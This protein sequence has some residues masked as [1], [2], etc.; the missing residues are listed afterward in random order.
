MTA[1]QFAK[2]GQMKF[3]C[4]YLP[5]DS[6]R[7]ASMPGMRISMLSCCA[8]AL[9]CVLIGMAVLAATGCQSPYRSDQGAFWGALGGA[10]L[11]AIVGKQLGNTAAGAALGGMTGLAA[12]ALIGDQL[13]EI[14]ARNRAEIERR[15]GRPVAAGAVPMEEVIAMTQAGVDQQVI[16][17]HVRA[18]GISRPLTS[19]DLIT[20]KQQGVR[21]SVIQAM[22]APYPARSVQPATYPVVV[23]EHYYGVPAYD[24]WYH[25]HC[26][27]RHVHYH[28]R[29]SP[30]VSWGVS[31]S[32]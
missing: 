17:N 7:M 15:L 16:I 2:N 18:H 20:L 4:S 14:E 22:Q 30:G 19:Q 8:T 12:G 23:E 24:P 31:V 25:Y 28:R 9:R 21:A 27:P 3:T 32:H 10:G 13:D 29:H 26:Q 11:G 6:L 1:I 5:M